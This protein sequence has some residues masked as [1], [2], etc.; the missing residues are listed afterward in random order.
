MELKDTFFARDREAADHR[1]RGQGVD[2]IDPSRLA[3]ARAGMGDLQRRNHLE[4][5]EQVRRPAC[6]SSS[7]VGRNRGCHLQGQPE[8]VTPVL[9]KIP[10]NNERRVGTS[11]MVFALVTRRP[12]AHFLPMECKSTYAAPVAPR[13]CTLL[14]DLV[15]LP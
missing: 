12:C 1:H 15:R 10:C 7:L 4:G 6:L 11:S 3:A 2:A 9:E 5:T 14:H 8:G 13:R